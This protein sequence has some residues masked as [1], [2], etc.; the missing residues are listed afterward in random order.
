[1]NELYEKM[2]NDPS[3]AVIVT[4]NHETGN[5]VYNDETKEEIKEDVFSNILFACD[6]KLF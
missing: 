5:L 3:C 1:M 2:I 6:F 4:G